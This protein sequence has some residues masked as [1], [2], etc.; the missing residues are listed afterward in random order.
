MTALFGVR[1][2]LDLEHTFL[3]LCMHDDGLLDMADLCANLEV[4]RLTAQNFIELLQS[5]HLIH[6]L[7]PY[8]YGKDVLRARFKIYLADAAIAPA[9]MRRE[10]PCLRTRRRWVWRRKRPSSNICSPDIT[11]AMC[12]SELDSSDLH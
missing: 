4:K 9:V 2:V 10:K 11:Q 8:G 7:P 5:A 1:R 12:A 6:R 3:Y